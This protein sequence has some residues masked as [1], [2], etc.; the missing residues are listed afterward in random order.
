MDLSFES[1]SLVG[2]PWLGI[3]LYLLTSL[4]DGYLTK[5]LVIDK[6]LQFQKQNP[7]AKLPYTE[8][9][10]L[11]RWIIGSPDKSDEYKIFIYKLILFAIMFLLQAPAISWYISS[12]VFLL[13][14]A[15]SKFQLLA[16][17]KAKLKN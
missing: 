11:L 8:A 16:K 14:A 15:N 5:R 4:L 17:I 13:A 9:N 7:G 12:G 2:A 6:N 3:I 10:V 1:F